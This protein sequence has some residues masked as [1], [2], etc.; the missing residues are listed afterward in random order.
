MNIF[1]FLKQKFIRIARL[2][3]RSH[4]KYPMLLFSI[5]FFRSY[6]IRENFQNIT[7]S[8]DLQTS[9]DF[10]GQ[11]SFSIAQDRINCTLTLSYINQQVKMIWHNHKSTNLMTFAN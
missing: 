3:I 11:E 2:Y 1:Q 7:P 10:I 5:L 4:L 8:N 9:N 6:P